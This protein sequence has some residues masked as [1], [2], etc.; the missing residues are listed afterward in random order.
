M[1]YMQC[2]KSVCIT[3]YNIFK[4]K[5]ALC[6]LSIKHLSPSN[7]LLNKSKIVDPPSIYMKLKTRF[8]VDR[9]SSFTTKSL[10]VVNSIIKRH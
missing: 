7:G 2:F 5:S 10:L 3:L 9:M 8:C 1:C 6:S 4:E